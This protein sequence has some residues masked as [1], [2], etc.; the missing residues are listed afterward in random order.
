ME[1]YSYSFGVPLPSVISKP[2]GIFQP[3]QTCR[4]NRLNLFSYNTAAGPTKNTQK[5][6]KELFMCFEVDVINEIVSGY[7][8]A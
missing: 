2:Y 4:L 6:P 1:F 3:C 7:V 5:G 8:R